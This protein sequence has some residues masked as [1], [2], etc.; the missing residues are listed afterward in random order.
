M[1]KIKR[2][3]VKYI[4]LF[5]IGIFTIFLGLNYFQSET[6]AEDSLCPSSMDPDSIECLDSL[7]ERLADLKNRNS[8]IEDRLDEE[9][10]QQLTLT[11]KLSYI[12][13]QI[14]QSEKL[15][16]SMEVDIAAQT[17]EI[18]LLEKEIQEKEDSISV[19]RQEI[20]ILEESVN[21]RVEE[22]YKYSFIGTLEIFLNGGNLDSILRRTKYLIETRAKDKAALEEMNDKVGELRAEELAIASEK[23]D[24][25]EKKKSLEEEKTDLVSQKKS[26]DAQ[27]A[28][29]N[30]L[31]AESKAREAELIAEYQANLERVSDLD[32]AII[33]YIN[34]HGDQMVNSGWVNQGEWIGRMGNTGCSNGAHLH[35]GLNSGTYYPNW[36]YFW[37]DVNLF[38]TG[39]LRKGG[40][41]FLYWSYDDWWSPL[42]YAGSKIL[43]LGGN[44]II[45]T[46][47][48][49]Q[50]NAIDLVSYTQNA[51]GYKYDGAPVYA[52]MSGTLYK[53]TESV[54]GGKY[55]MIEHEN[56]MVSI[57]LHLQ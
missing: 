54:C 20:A 16:E 31:L 11:E 5:V 39:Y 15:I 24:L 45:M 42:I 41:S 36:G 27:K 47:D 35:F 40:N 33:A 2:N 3:K 17:V 9:E 37:S 57:Y 34:A 23:E 53:G 22:S 32:A 30:R 14:A 29:Q 8:D 51:W 56:G 48:E 50:G 19:M 10:Y 49:H 25:E 21:Q 52:F 1:K 26:L 43:P 28:E 55:A 38:S 6:L 4:F 13:N 46:Q 12:T 7:R 18:S 44:Y